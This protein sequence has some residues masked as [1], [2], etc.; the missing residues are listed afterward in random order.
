MHF[1][2]DGSAGTWEKCLFWSYLRFEDAKCQRK[3]GE[4]IDLNESG[5]ASLCFS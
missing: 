5:V 3:K 2:E 4:N 1:Y